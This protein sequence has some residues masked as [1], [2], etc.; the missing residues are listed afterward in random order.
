MDKKHGPWTI[1]DQK[2][3]Y[4]SQWIELTEDQVTRPDGKPGVFSFVTMPDGAS[5]LPMDTEGNVYLVKQFRYAVGTE[6]VE[7]ATGAIDPGEA[8]DQT[9][10]R[11][12]EEELGIQGDE[13]IS[14]GSTEPMTSALACT[15]HLFLVRTLTFVQA[16]PDG[17]ERIEPLKVSF[18]KAVDM[19]FQ[20]KITHAQSC[21]LILKAKDW[22]EKHKA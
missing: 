4:K 14:L 10:R 21:I 6:T 16:R 3:I 22:L 7:V 5:M 1:H 18:E 12:L 20:G 9:A 11:E 19:V 15:A 8:A 17:N 2:Q 13:W